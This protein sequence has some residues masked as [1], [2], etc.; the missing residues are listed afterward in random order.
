MKTAMMVLYK[1]MLLEKDYLVDLEQ[2]TYNHGKRTI[3]LR[4]KNNERMSF[5]D[6]RI[7]ITLEPINKMIAGEE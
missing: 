1:L 4:Y 2:N 5:E 7:L 3:L 6:T